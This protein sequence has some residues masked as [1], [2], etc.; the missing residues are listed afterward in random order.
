MLLRSTNSWWHGMKT[1][2]N[3]ILLHGCTIFA[4]NPKMFEWKVNVLKCMTLPGCNVFVVNPKIFV[5]NVIPSSAFY[6]MPAMLCLQCYGVQPTAEQL[7]VWYENFKEMHA[8]ACL[9]RF[10]GWPKD[11]CVERKTSL[12]LILPCNCNAFLMD[13]YWNTPR[14]HSTARLQWSH[15]PGICHGNKKLP[16]WGSGGWRP[17]K[18]MATTKSMQS[19]KWNLISPPKVPR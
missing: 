15:P 9:E 7:M 17:V 11:A 3:C 13:W 2:M 18:T 10:C 19:Y 16:I 12:K 5:C 14:V 4:V 8:A 6:C 1:S